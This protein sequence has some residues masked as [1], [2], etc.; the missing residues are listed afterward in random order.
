M[1]AFVYFSHVVNKDLRISLVC[2]MIWTAKTL[3]YLELT[4]HLFVTTKNH[5]VSCGC[6]F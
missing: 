3:R 4:F 1:P 6:L 2:I 5:L